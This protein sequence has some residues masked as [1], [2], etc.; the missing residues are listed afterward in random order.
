MP[1]FSA[2][3]KQLK[4]GKLSYVNTIDAVWRSLLLIKRIVFVQHSLMLYSLVPR[5]FEEE[6]KGPDTHCMRMCKVYRAF[7][8]LRFP[9]GSCCTCMAV[10]FF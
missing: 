8:S 6:E 2:A 5:P 4:F 7:S 9:L 10:H 3:G 1:T